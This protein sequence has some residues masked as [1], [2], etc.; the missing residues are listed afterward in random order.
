[1]SVF[2]PGQSWEI[3]VIPT[4]GESKK[5]MAE[6]IVITI[7][8][9]HHL[10]AALKAHEFKSKPGDQSQQYPEHVNFARHDVTFRHG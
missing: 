2:G 6:P 10:P 4:G 9:P 7:G 8:A 5:V 3:H 1:M